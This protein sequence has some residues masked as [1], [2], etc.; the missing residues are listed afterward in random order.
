MR[1][2]GE[3]RRGG[4]VNLD[5]EV[6][7][8][9][10]RLIWRELRGYGEGVMLVRCCW[11]LPHPNYV[12]FKRGML[13]ICPTYPCQSTVSQWHPTVASLYATC[14]YAFDTATVH[15]YLSSNGVG[16]ANNSTFISFLS[17]IYCVHVGGG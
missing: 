14:L 5:P 1:G 10:G 12:L 15:A 17:D 13:T 6:L 16:L 9:S 11:V 7:C 3:E 8:G 4:L 2:Q